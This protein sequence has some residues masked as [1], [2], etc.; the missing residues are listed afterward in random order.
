MHLIFF[1]KLVDFYSIKKQKP[2]GLKQ[3]FFLYS[4]KLIEYST[5]AVI[6]ATA[7]PFFA[8]WNYN[9]SRKNM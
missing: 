1:F 8:P 2:I 9:T 7:N 3:N 6:V 4:L 5:S